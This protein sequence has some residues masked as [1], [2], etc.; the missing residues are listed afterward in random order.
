MSSPDL[1]VAELLLALQ[2]F[3][4]GK[5]QERARVYHQS[6]S[7]IHGCLNNTPG[8]RRLPK[9]LQRRVEDCVGQRPNEG[10]GK[11]NSKDLSQEE[12]WKALT[13]REMRDILQKSG[14]EI[15]MH[16]D[17]QFYIEQSIASRH[18]ILAEMQSRAK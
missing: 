17:K 1:L 9:N 15:A 11:L 18:R 16:R 2:Q 12:T 6:I 7:D 8:F 4:S 13:M 5:E 14:I 10:W 3:S